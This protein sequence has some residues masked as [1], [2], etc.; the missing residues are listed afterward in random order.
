MPRGDADA[1]LSVAQAAALLGVHPNTIR[2]W[3]AA[4]VV[5]LAI[6]IALLVIGGIGAFASAMLA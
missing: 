5:G 2:Q 4:G 3:A 6:A 1:L